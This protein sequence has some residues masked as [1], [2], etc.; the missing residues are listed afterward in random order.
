M[1]VHPCVLVSRLC[2]WASGHMPNGRPTL[3]RPERKFCACRTQVGPVNHGPVWLGW[4]IFV[5]CWCWFAVRRKHYFTAE[6]QCW[7]WLIRPLRFALG[8]CFLSASHRA[9]IEVSSH[10]HGVCA[11]SQGAAQLGLAPARLQL[12][13]VNVGLFTLLYVWTTT[14]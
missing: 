10:G 4:L 5:C 3:W 8:S 13:Y 2:T 7:F 12:T 11:S 1:C 14:L 9:I 6:K